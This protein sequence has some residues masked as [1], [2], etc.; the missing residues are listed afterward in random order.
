MII[1]PEI[2]RYRF[3]DLRTGNLLADNQ[4]TNILFS[5]SILHTHWP[6][7]A[8]IVDVWTFGDWT[9]NAMTKFV[10]TALEIDADYLV[11]I[12]SDVGWEPEAIKTLIAGDKDVATGWALGRSHPF[13]LHQA[14]KYDEE[15][16][17]FSVPPTKEVR[18]RHGWERIAATGGELVVWKADV[19]K[20]IPCDWFFGDNMQHPVTGRIMTEDY[21]F[22]SRAAEYGVEIWVN[23]DVPLAHE[24]AGVYTFKGDLHFE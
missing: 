8:E 23:W 21:Y 22:A 14:L 10:N 12:S 5:K 16:K 19:F 7:G 11:T 3:Q 4:Y 13:R 24:S 20:R 1:G 15:R 6:T 9:P 18:D 2:T 17:T